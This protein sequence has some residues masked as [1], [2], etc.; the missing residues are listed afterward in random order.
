MASLPAG[1]DSM[2]NV[3]DYPFA[4]TFLG[5]ISAFVVTSEIGH[6]CAKASVEET[7]VSI[8]EQ[9]MLGLVALMMGFTFAMALTRLDAR[10]DALLTEANAIGTAALR[11]HLLPEPEASKSVKL[12][13]D[14][15]QIELDL[16]HSPGPM[17]LLGTVVAR[18]NEMQNN[19]WEEMRSASAKDGEMVPTGLY[20]QSLNEVFDS[21]EKRLTALHSRVPPVVFLSLYAVSTIAMWFAGYAS[22]VKQRLW[23]VPV[24]GM[25]VLLAAVILLIQD[26]DQPIG[27][28][29]SVSQQPLLDTAKSIDSYQIAHKN[30][31]ALHHP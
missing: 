6:R 25:G 31:Q 12:L 13:R 7:N 16:V 2:L 5:S 23:R 28:F 22:F 26:L 1:R 8:L 17:P 20:M 27:G 18:S 10:R 11:A 30:G 4:I 19:L 29:I 24:Y 9:A 15:L 3:A 21:R 14:Y